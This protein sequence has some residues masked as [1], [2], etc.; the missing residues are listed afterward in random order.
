M[1]QKMRLKLESHF[2]TFIHLKKSLGII[3]LYL[4][5]FELANH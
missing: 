2:F 5:N 4:A 1:K 3:A